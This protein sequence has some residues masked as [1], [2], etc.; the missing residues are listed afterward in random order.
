MDDPARGCPY[1][2]LTQ[3]LNKCDFELLGNPERAL[4]PGHG[5]QLTEQLL[6]PRIIPRE[7]ENDHP[8]YGARSEPEDKQRDG[9][10]RPGEHVEDQV[11]H[12]TRPWK[13]WGATSGLN[14]ASW[15]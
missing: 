9:Q 11:A 13:S 12:P 6:T 7:G 14:L 10:R 1:K 3:A 8:Q 2:A 4:D 5:I 15:R